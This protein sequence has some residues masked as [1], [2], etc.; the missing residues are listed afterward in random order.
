MFQL[1]NACRVYNKSNGEKSFYIFCTHELLLVLVSCMIEHDKISHSH[2]YCKHL[3]VAVTNV[4]Y[5]NAYQI[6]CEMFCVEMW[7]PT[8]KLLIL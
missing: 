6:V 4:E 1:V 8:P 5:V 2:P 7:S 3:M